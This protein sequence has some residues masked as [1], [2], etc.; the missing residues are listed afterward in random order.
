MNIFM[1]SECPIQSAYD[2][3]RVHRN[4]LI[5]ELSQILSVAHRILDGD[6]YADANGFYKATHKNHPSCIF[7]RSC[8]EAYEWA[9][10][11][12]MALHQYYEEDRGKTHASKR[13][14]DALAEVP[15]NIGNYSFSPVIAAPET[16]KVYARRTSVPLAYQAYLRDKFI[17]W[18]SRQKPVKL[19]WP[20]GKP[21]WM[22]E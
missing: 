21:E 10:L 9:Y 2:H 17:E 3:C 7:V 16:Y 14:L 12:L 18:T 11:H 1:T 8:P 4:K 22:Y 19:E 6:E 13:L 5:T 20:F 15:H